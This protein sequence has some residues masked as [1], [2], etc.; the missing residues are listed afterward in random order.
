MDLARPAEKMV[1]VSHLVIVETA[2]RHKVFSY[3]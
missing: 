1:V 2:Q 3:K